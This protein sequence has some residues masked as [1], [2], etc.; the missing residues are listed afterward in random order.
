MAVCDDRQ[1]TQ[2]QREAAFLQQQRSGVM[3]AI[4]PFTGA[5]TLPNLIDYLNR[6]VYPVLRQA[7]AKLN[8]VYR[9]VTDN[10][11][12]ANPLGYFF[13]EET[14]NAD[15]TAG[16]LRLNA[17]PE[18]TATVIR[19]SQTNGRL[20]DVAPWLDVMAGSSTTPLGVVTIFDASDPARF[21][22]FDLDT[23]T[24]Q[25]AY[26]DLGVTIT[27]SSADNPFVDDEPVVIAFIP[28]VA[29]TG[30][31]VPVGSITPMSAH[32]VLGNP[33]N[34]TAAPTEIA[35][36]ALS[37]L[38]RTTTA[39][40]VASLTATQSSTFLRVNTLNTQPGGVGSGTA[41]SS[42]LWSSIFVQDL[43]RVQDG[44]FYL[45]TFGAFS[46]PGARNLASLAGLG[47][48]AILSPNYN[49]NV[50]A[51]TSVV[52]DFPGTNEVQ[53][54]A[55]TGDVTAAQNSNTTAFRSFTALSVLGRAA[56]TSGIPTEIA[57]TPSSE[58]VLHEALGS[59]AWGQ[60]TTGGYSDASI[61]DAKIT[62]RQAL[63]LWGRAA[64]SVG[65]P[66]DISTTSGS[67]TVM[68][69]SGGTI[70]WG[71]VA[72]AGLADD[73]IT[74][75]KLRNSG[76][77]SVI[78]RSANSSGDPADISATAASD[79]VLR[80]SG[81]VLGF[82]TV[83]TGGIANDAV[84][85]AK[86]RNSGALSVIGRS[87]NSSGDPADISASAASGAVLRES[88]STIGWGVVANAGLA[89]MAAG[90]VKGRQIDA[91]TGVPVDLTGAEV[92]E[93]LRIGTVQS[94][95]GASPLAITL[96]ADTTFLSI[97][98]SGDAD[99]RTI[100]G[101]T[102][103]RVVLMMI[104]AASGI[105]TLK[106]NFSA[107]TS[108][109]LILPGLIDHTLRVRDT[110]WLIG[111]GTDGWQVVRTRVAAD[112]IV[113]NAVTDAKIRQSAALSV[114]GRSANSTGNVA[115]IS[116]TASSDQVLRVSGTTLGFG[117]VATAG[118]AD[119]SITDAK[120]RNSG[121]LSVIGR[122]ANSTGDPADIS[123]TAASGAVL[124]ESGSTLGFGT[125][126]TAGITDDAVTNAKL[127]NMAAATVKGRA[128][129]A[130][131]GDPTDLTQ[132]Q[133]SDLFRIISGVTD[134]PAPGS[135]NDYAVAE[136]TKLLRINPSSSGD[137][138]LTGILQGSSNTGG[139][140]RLFNQGSTTVER[141]V[142]KHANAGSAANNQ[143]ILPEG[144]DYI[145]DR[146]GDAVDLQYIGGRWQ[147]IS[148]QINTQ[149]ITDNAVTNGK[150][151]DSG[152]LSVI[153][154][155]ANSAGD[156][157]DIAAANDGEILRR[158]GTTLGFGTIATAGLADNS[159]TDA[160]LRDSAAL[161]VIGRAVNSSGDP[162]DITAGTNDRVLV[163]RSNTLVF[164]Q[165]VV[166]DIADGVITVAKLAGIGANTLLG[167]DTA[168]TLTPNA[169]AVG[170][171]TVVGRVAGN[172][173]AAQL[174]T[175]QVAN[176]AIT[177]GKLRQSAALSVIGRSANSTGDVADISGT[178]SSDAVL[179]VSG[180]SLGF[181]TVATA[182][183]AN[184]AVT[185]A[186]LATMAQ[187]RIKGRAEG[188]GTGDPTDL[189]PTEV[190][191]II[192]GEAPTWT[193]AHTFNGVVSFN[194]TVDLSGAIR[195]TEILSTGTIGLDNVSLSGA[196]V[197]RM[198][199]SAWLLTGIVP[200]L[201]GRVVLLV[202]AHASSDG[203]VFL[204]SGSSTAA[205]QFAGIGTSRV[206][207][208]GEMAL[209]WYD[210]VD[211]RW[212][213]LCRDETDL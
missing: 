45:N 194:D 177:D 50:N 54:A 75:A 119:D 71:T 10:A 142:L 113:D 16:R 157:A 170:T 63:S 208:P 195:F 203:I 133:L 127:A 147:V 40:D 11:P 43:P 9:Q 46:A 84:T 123:A 62:N 174:A 148:Q 51:S 37:V 61:T 97:T 200:A 156:P 15:P 92:A 88:G 114:I 77:L 129:G 167:N 101:S 126:A 29:S 65:A 100:T 136:T 25:G 76:A 36:N 70:G 176:N 60:V 52:I 161:S 213:L 124:R 80:E 192:D 90:T 83:A 206:I 159:V 26:W 132:T 35:I 102:L 117:T 120:L 103:G 74:D 158:S 104:F 160:K 67:A 193:A 107:G 130:G 212:R 149:R 27:E 49:L 89:N 22:R 5:A 198:T 181:G 171:N 163:R 41:P 24:D 21:L 151:R 185:N 162:G 183:L 197:L 188:A 146:F 135:Y 190:V 1:L 18:N 96:N 7:R 122:S 140:I 95:G 139:W 28:G 13:S 3:Q 59:I 73:S 143:F 17:V 64:N 53:R 207:R 137:V 93:L 55:L 39:A 99:I 20:S 189:T 131:T 180:T 141:I 210:G 115:D 44:Q 38:A 164:D 72:T 125:I 6:E 182:G 110:C 57:A 153:G 106:H 205:N 86:L 118:H 66:A 187:S 154:R 42:I 116:G 184:N 199:G 178:A 168:G 68:R 152:A 108:N 14:A 105:K 12:S 91:S 2:A 47:L 191:S 173:V 94:E 128:L 87:A 109:A 172:I 150:L 4:R 204:N 155:S 69:E 79:A 33:T 144:A 82:G 121:A 85:D 78:G 209:A 169:I 23:M 30:T 175:G 211:S 98:T 196:S 31:T 145:L 138:E 32:T 186:K 179:R 58:A 48:S 201:T 8:D 81:S 56:G 165:I 134:T 111:L 19:I 202:N 166:G 34:A 112:G